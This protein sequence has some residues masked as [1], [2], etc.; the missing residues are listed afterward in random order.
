MDEGYVAYGG[1]RS[2]ASSE[3]TLGRLAVAIAISFIIVF[4]LMSLRAELRYGACQSGEDPD[5]EREFE[6][7]SRVNCADLAP[8]WHR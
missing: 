4:G 5:I 6:D 1:Q 2:R 7:G 8:P 3:V